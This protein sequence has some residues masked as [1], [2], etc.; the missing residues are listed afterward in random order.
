VLLSRGQ[1]FGPAPDADKEARAA[2][3]QKWRSWWDRR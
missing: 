1:D 2:A 3:Q